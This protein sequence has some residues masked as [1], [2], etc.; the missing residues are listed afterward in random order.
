MLY[1]AHCYPCVYG[2]DGEVILSYWCNVLQFNVTWVEALTGEATNR[3]GV[4]PICW[5][6]GCPILNLG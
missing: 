1:L 4:S 6:D 2:M 3:V 5:F